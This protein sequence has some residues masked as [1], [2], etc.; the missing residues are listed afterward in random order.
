MSAH[1]YIDGHEFELP[2]VDGVLVVLAG[3]PIVQLQKG[4]RG[5]GYINLGPGCF[6]TVGEPPKHQDIKSKAL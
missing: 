4:G 3:G 5:V 2:D 1:I 6:V